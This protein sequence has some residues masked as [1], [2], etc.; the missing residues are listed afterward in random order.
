MPRSDSQASIPV[1]RLPTSSATLYYQVPHHHSTHSIFRATA[2]RRKSSSPSSDT[3]TLESQ[4]FTKGS[5]GLILLYEPS[6]TRLDFIF[7]IPSED[8]AMFWPEQWLPYE[9]GFKH[10]RIHT[11]S[12]DSDWS[13]AQHSVLRIRDFAQS[14]LS[15]ISNSQFPKSQELLRS[16]SYPTAWAVSLSIPTG[17]KAYVKELLLDSDTVTDINDNFRHASK[18]IQLWSFFE[19]TPTAGAMIVDKS[20]AIIGLPN[21]K[22]EH[23]P[24]NHR[25][26]CKFTSS[27]DP[28][29]IILRDSLK[30]TI[31][32][33]D[34][35]CSRLAPTVY[36]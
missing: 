21:E 7:I 5:L 29:Y 26:L 2:W 32:L 13:K 9:P 14:L 35:D 36:P 23:L 30:T 17:A 20:S 24:K 33:V 1:L 6:E 22:T 8:P 4:S 25:H 27:S 34:K 18:D 28:C 31:E 11:F 3:A 15:S 16:Y 10:V 19:G 12:Y